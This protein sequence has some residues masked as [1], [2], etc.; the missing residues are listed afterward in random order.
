MAKIR[1]KTQLLINADLDLGSNKIINLS[2]GT[3]N[4]DGVNYGQ[5]VSYVGEKL[6]SALKYK[7]T[8]DMSVTTGATSAQTILS[9]AKVGDYY[10]VSSTSEQTVFGLVWNANDNLLISSDLG[11]LT[12][13][14][15]SAAVTGID[16][17]DNTEEAYVYPLTTYTAGYLVS[18]STNRTLQANY[19]VATTNINSSSS[20]PNSAALYAALNEKVSTLASSPAGS[21]VKVNVNSQG[22]VTSGYSTIAESEVTSLVSDLSKK[23]P[24]ATVVSGTYYK[25]NVNTYGLVT[26]GV[27]SLSESDVTS[28]VS[29]LAGKVPTATVVSGTFYKVNVN[30]Y[31]LVTQGV[32]SLTTSDISNI[33]TYVESS[34]PNKLRLLSTYSTVS[35]STLGTSYTITF[36]PIT[37]TDR[38]KFTSTNYIPDSVKVSINGLELASNEYTSTFV[39]VSGSDNYYSVTINNGTASVSSSQVLND[40]DVITA[41]V[42]YWYV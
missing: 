42:Q 5:L 6:T 3:N 25:V 23:V 24:T 13:G 29:D 12:T 17:V 15:R 37:T 27:S 33:Q 28:L 40:Q 21:Y 20:I 2:S 11:T 18:A 35:G 9:N 41:S 7:G 8:I 1:S 39:T 22:Q 34:L 16:K 31:G 19:S 10:K 26:Q 14:N 32:S 4:S 38:T 30:T 36:K